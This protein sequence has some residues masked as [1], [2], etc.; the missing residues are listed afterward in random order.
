LLVGVEES[1]SSEEETVN[2][3]P[4]QTILPS[5][6]RSTRVK[7]RAAKQITNAKKQLKK[8]EVIICPLFISIN[9]ELFY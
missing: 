1:T 3:K 6:K 9:L 7:Q 5:P 8:I 4:L 2:A